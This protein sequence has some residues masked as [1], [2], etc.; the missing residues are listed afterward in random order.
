MKKYYFLFF[1]IFLSITVF[2]QNTFKGTFYPLHQDIEPVIV[3]DSHFIYKGKLWNIITSQYSNNNSK[4]EIKYTDTIWYYDQNGSYKTKVLTEKDYLSLK[5][6][7][8]VLWINFK[9]YTRSK[10]VNR[11]YKEESFASDCNNQT[12]TII[13]I[14]E[15]YKPLDSIVLQKDHKLSM[16]HPSPAIPLPENGIIKLHHLLLN[17]SK[18]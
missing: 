3:L 13:L 4:Y 14:I 7:K 17:T 16:F 8:D 6:E 15:S 12:C 18:F 2:C 1:L 5:W 10:P 9:A 11:R